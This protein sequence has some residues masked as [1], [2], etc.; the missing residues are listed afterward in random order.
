MSPTTTATAAERRQ[1]DEL[2]YLILPGLISGDLL[3]RMR[4]RVEELFA[5]EGDAAG[6]EFKQEPGCRRLAN[7]VDKGD[8]FRD[9]IA[10]PRLLPYVR[11]VLG[12]SIKLSSLN[13]RS[14]GPGSAGQPFHVDMGA[15]PDET[16]Y[17]V[18]NTIWLLDA[19]TQETGGLRLIPGSHH[20][21]K[22]P[23]DVLPDPLAS[24][25]EEGHVTAEAGSVVVVNAHVWHAGTGNR[26]TS[27][28]TALHG[29]YCRRDKPQQQYQKSLLRPEVQSGLSPELRDLLALDDPLNDDLSATV[30]VRS[31]FLK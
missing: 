1:L 11:H 26:G 6:A 20:W 16:G 15:I 30:T 2:G 9:M 25:P 5:I 10:E 24:H 19:Y 21:Q 17:W 27:P 28:R 4:E 23:Q 22:R 12:P 18:C 14:V 13:A 8:L 3:A 7:L 29:F 31:G